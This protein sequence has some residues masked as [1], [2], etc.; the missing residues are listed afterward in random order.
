MFRAPG[1]IPEH[2]QADIPQLSMC[3][4]VTRRVPRPR[5]VPTVRPISL[6][7]GVGIDGCVSL[8]ESNAID[9]SHHL[10]QQC[11]RRSL[12][13]RLF[14]SD[15]L[16]IVVAHILDNRHLP[17]YQTPIRFPLRLRL[18]SRSK[19]GQRTRHCHHEGRRALIISL[20]WASEV[21]LLL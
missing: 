14:P 2:P 15:S 18:T 5:E 9:F 20:L 19:I 13:Y 4:T 12:Q 17:S 10:R 8:Q 7:R 3:W 6:H 1:A 11:T 16:T 21:P